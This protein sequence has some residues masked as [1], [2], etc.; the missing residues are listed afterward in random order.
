[1]EKAAKV[2]G[3]DWNRHGR[4]GKAASVHATGGSMS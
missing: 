2:I 1:M 3:R 4:G